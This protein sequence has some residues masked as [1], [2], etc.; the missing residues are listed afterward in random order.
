[1]CRVSYTIL[2]CRFTGMQLEV[3]GRELS[4]NVPQCRDTYPGKNGKQYEVIPIHASAWGATTPDFPLEVIDKF[5]STR[6]RGARQ[7][8]S[9]AC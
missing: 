6:P 5:Q 9:T 1:M 4:E 2:T 7:D 3:V 8:S